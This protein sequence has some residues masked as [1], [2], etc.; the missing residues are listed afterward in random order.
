M[1]KKQPLIQRR[2]VAQA[3]PDT[4]I[5]EHYGVLSHIPT[6]IIVLGT[7]VTFT[8]ISAIMLVRFLTTQEPMIPTIATIFVF[9]LLCNA[10]IS[11][12][13]S[14]F[15]THYEITIK[16]AILIGVHILGILFSL[17]FFYVFMNL[18]VNRA[19]DP[20]NTATSMPDALLVIAL[21]F[22]AVL[23]YEALAQIIRTII[24]LVREKKD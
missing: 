1:T 23:F 19:Q 10:S 6:S 7:A 3:K 18:L 12:I 15:T 20:N 9:A 13:K 14:L 17:G 8:L 16:P 24:T 5:P 22:V 4:L 21:V 11:A 2:A